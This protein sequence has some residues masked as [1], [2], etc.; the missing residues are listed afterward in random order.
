MGL[1]FALD[2]IDLIGSGPGI[3]FSEPFVCRIVVLVKDMMKT[4][5]KDKNLQER[6]ENKDG[7]TEAQASAND[8]NWNAHHQI[9]EEGNEINPD[10][11][12]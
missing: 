6:E 8:S 3:I 11:I 2:Q 1:D 4:D 5:P 12:K 9:D 10:D 7:A